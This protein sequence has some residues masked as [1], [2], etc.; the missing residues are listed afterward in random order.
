MPSPSIRDLAT[1]FDVALRVVNR[2]PRTRYLY[3]QSIRFY[4]E[5]LESQGIPATLNNLNRHLITGWMADLSERV[6]VGTVRNRLRGM[7]RFCRWLEKEGE[8]DKAPTLGVE[9]PAPKEK[10]NRTLTDDELAAMI[11]ACARPRTRSGTWDAHAFEGRRDEVIIRLLA[12][13]GIRVSELAGITL[14][15]LDRSHEVIYVTGKG[16]R[17]RVVPYGA[18]TTQALDRY[19]RL[20]TAHPKATKT[21][22]LILTQRGPITADGI[23]WRL[24]QVGEQAGVKDVHPHAFRH[25]AAHRWLMAGGSERGLMAVMGWR[26]DAMLSTYARST[27]VERAHAEHRR[28]RLGDTV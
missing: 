8:V 16:D 18:R 1:S 4:C 12:D 26:S 5:W 7:R 27:Q 22:R 23:R 19:L 21:D 10:P 2:S 13:C 11:K 17:P 6:E 14:D 3:Q 9:M 28:L 20:R 24:E 15:D 25:T